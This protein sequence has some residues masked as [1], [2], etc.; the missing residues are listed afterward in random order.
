[1]EIKFPLKILVK[2]NKTKTRIV[3]Y[4]DVCVVEVAAKAESNKAN[5]ELIK[6]FSKLSGKRVRIKT[7]LKNKKKV[8]DCV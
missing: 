2:P 7:G 5:I 1:M 6:F 3:S 8:I 4:G